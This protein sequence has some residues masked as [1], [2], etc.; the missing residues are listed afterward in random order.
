VLPLEPEERVT[1]VVPTREMTTEEY[2]TMVTR[3]GTVKRLRLEQLNTARKAGIRALTLDEGDELIAVMKTDGN[4]DIF[5]ATHDGMAICFNESDVR[6]MG[7]D[8]AGVRGIKLDEGDFVVGA[9]VVKDGASLLTVTENGYGKRTLAE[10]YMRS[11][12]DS[13]DRQP[14]KRG[15]KGLK[16]YGITKK[17]GLIAGVRM[18][19]DTDDVMIISNDGTII[20]MPAKDINIYK[21]GTQGVIVMRVEGESKVISVEKVAAEEESAQPENSEPSEAE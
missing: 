14:Q 19:T 4:N 6:P 17:T 21:R 15:G 7:R 3:N 5:L 11:S 20:R 13:T 18:V 10:E 2:L 16:N 1:A 9:E 12:E 8:A